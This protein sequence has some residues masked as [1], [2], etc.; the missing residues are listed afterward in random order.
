LK[1]TLKRQKF[2]NGEQS[3]KNCLFGNEETIWDSKSI[4]KPKL[5]ITGPKENGQN[6]TAAALL[7][8]MDHLKIIKLTLSSLYS[9][10]NRTVEDAMAEFIREASRAG[11]AI[12][13]IPGI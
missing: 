1:V 4:F 7:D 3:I 13:F 6:V 8:E 11:R 5:L 10:Q 9:S 2:R 12:L